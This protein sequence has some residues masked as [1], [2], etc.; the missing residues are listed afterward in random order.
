MVLVEML[1]SPRRTSR[2]EHRREAIRELAKLD[3]KPELQL[4]MDAITAL[5]SPNENSTFRT[6]S[7]G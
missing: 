3:G 5:D 2:E 4:I 1:L 7:N 6:P